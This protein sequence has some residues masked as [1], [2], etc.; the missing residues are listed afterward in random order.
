MKNIFIGIGLTSLL[1][2]VAISFFTQG[3]AESTAA[4]D[5]TSIK[6]DI[7][8]LEMDLHRIQQFGDLTLDETKAELEKVKSKIEAK[9]KLLAAA[10]SKKQNVN[11]Q[12]DAQ[13]QD[14]NDAAESL[15]AKLGGE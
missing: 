11:A 14:V 8:K 9:E 5:V 12:A 3:R 10:E 6:I 7:A 13:R 1:A 4:A 15:D 2:F